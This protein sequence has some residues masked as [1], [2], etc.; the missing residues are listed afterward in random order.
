MSALVDP[1][2]LQRLSSDLG[3]DVAVQHRFV[4]DFL[5][6]WHTREL[7]LRT[8]IAAADLEDADIVLLSIRS[9]SKMLGAVR[10]DHTASQLHSTVKDKD[11]SGCRRQ[12]PHLSEVGVDTCMAL[13][14]HIKR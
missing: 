8:A 3:G 2:P 13:S 10:L 14:R 4:N 9:S 6:L 5:A 7:R 1:A 11:L 12:L